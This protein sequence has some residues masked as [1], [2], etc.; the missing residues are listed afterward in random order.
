MKKKEIITRTINICPYTKETDPSDPNIIIYKTYRGYDNETRKTT[1][2]CY[3]HLINKSWLQSN[4][5]LTDIIHVYIILEGDETGESQ[6]IDEDI[7][8]Q[9][10]DKFNVPAIG[11]M[12][13][14]DT[15]KLLG[16]PVSPGDYKQ[17]AKSEPDNTVSTSNKIHRYCLNCGEI[18][19]VKRADL[20]RGSGLYCSRGC[21]NTARSNNK[22]K[23]KLQHT[24]VKCGFNWESY[25]EEDYC[26]IECENVDK[27]LN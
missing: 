6:I 14:I 2:I 7:K 23:E 5:T 3:K 24:C 19:E 21:S 18:S 25:E 4:N 12:D 27:N 15:G 10:R 11:L 16:I 26:S 13:E 1:G 20:K 17:N 22:Y 9:L 8:K